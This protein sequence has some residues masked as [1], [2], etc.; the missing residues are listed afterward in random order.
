M[1]SRNL[2]NGLLTIGLIVVLIMA[3]GQAP[4]SENTK[5]DTMTF[6]K[7]TPEEERVIIRKGTEA[8]FT[9]K[10][11][12][13]H[14]SGTY[15]CRQC[16]A[17]LFNSTDKFDSGCGWPSFDDAIPGAVKRRLTPTVTA[18]KS[19]ARTA[20]GISGMSSSAKG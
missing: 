5:G 7:L 18:P 12:Q 6:N 16:G 4:R 10:Y 8:P 17:P 11:Y 14:E 15:T 2:Q 13:H 20:A 9:G 1:K 3:V 19:P